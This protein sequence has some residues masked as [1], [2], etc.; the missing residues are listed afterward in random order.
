MNALARIGNA[1]RAGIRAWA[2]DMAGGTGRWPRDAML[3]ATPRQELAARRTI[4]MRANYLVDNSPS[5]RSVVDN[6][7]EHLIGDGVT[8]RSG[9]PNET[10]R[11]ALEAVWNDFAAGP[12]IE[13]ADADLA[14]FL[15]R[16]VRTVVS[17]GEAFVRL[18]TTA[19]GLR[20]QLLSTEQVAS[21]A[22]RELPG[23]ARIIAGV[24][25]GP[26]GERRAYWIR[27][28]AD[29]I[30]IGMTSDP[31]RVPAEDICHVIDP[32]HAG[33]I[34]GISWL[35]AVGTRL[36]ELDRLEDALCSRMR[37]AALFAGFV[38]DTEGTSGF[39]EGRTDPQE[40]S[41]EPGTMRIL[42]PGCT[43]AF[44][45]LPD[46]AGSPELLRHM[47]RSI[48]AGT[49][50]PY[51]ILA[52]DLSATNYSSAKMG[53]ESFRRRCKALQ[54]SMIGSRLLHPVWRRLVAVEILAGRLTAPGFVRSGSAYYAA[55]FLWPQ[56]Q[57]LDP[58]KDAE[59]DQILL[60][61]AIKSRQQIIAERGR[62]MADVD[63]EI[64]A[65]AR[66]LPSVR[67]IAAPPQA[68]RA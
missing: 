67:P 51:E 11:G 44:P 39:G 14:E 3:W 54:A 13:G 40:M 66:P 26:N 55:T 58:L 34:R 1:F 20:V 60:A 22:N 48:A 6:W 45:D 41:M 65:D 46:T 33:A 37:V 49:G 5:A 63:Q 57:S 30:W 61:N 24:E 56:P 4:A 59:A 10:I 9:H 53:A 19:D 17:G 29:D 64:A 36:L 38:T 62:D 31:V 42:P 50:L 16:V 28:Q 25:V 43:V 27:P 12:D 35:T 18:I 21:D 23:G 52:A 68:A 8:M 7:T 2:H 47:L 32:R 15:R